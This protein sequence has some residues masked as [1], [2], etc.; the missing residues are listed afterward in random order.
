MT[1]EM[2]NQQW[3][4][5]SSLGGHGCSRDALR[6]TKRSSAWLLVLTAC[7]CFFAWT[8]RAA[9]V[10]APSPDE[11]A[12]QQ[13][14][15]EWPPPSTPPGTPEK[16]RWAWYRAWLKPHESFFN[17]HERDLFAESVTLNLQGL[18]DAHEVFLNGT[19][20]GAGGAFPP[21]FASGRL[22]FHRH[23]IP[24]GLMEKG[25][26]NE[27]A[28]RVYS[29]SGRGG[30]LEEA[31]F[32]MGYAIE[33]V[34]QGIWQIQW[35]D[36]PKLTGSALMRQ[37]ATAAFDSYRESSRVLGEAAGFVHGPKL[38]P[39]ESLKR[40]RPHPDLA[41][42]GLLQE[43][44]VAQPTHLSFDERGRLYVSQYRQYP[45]PAGLKMI[46]RDKFYRAH[47]DK[48]PLPPPHHVKGRDAITIHE[49]TNGDGVFD[50]HSFFQ[51]GLNLANAALRGR[52]GVWVM[53]PPY[54]LFY[55]DENFDDIP[56]GPPEV[57]LAGFGIEDTHSVATGLVWGLDG[58]LYGSQGS[59]TSSHILRPGLDST[60]TTPAYFE[61]AMVWRYHPKT[62]AYEVFAEGGGNTFGLEIDG[63]GRLFSGH[64]GGETR[65]WHFVQGGYYLKPGL[66]PGKF[67]PQRNPYTFGELKVM[68]PISSVQ[69]FSHL[70]AV[71][72]G[73]SMP[74]GFRGKIF[75]ID[76]IHSAV[77][78]AQRLSKGSTFETTEAGVALGSDDPG[79][80]PVFIVNAPDGAL[81]VAD[82][83]EHYIA[84][85]QHYQSQIDPT[86]GRIY[87]LRDKRGRLERD[88]DLS[89][90]TSVELVGLLSHPNKWHRHMAV[91]L[92]GE[93]RD[94]ASIQML[95]KLVQTRSRWGSLGALWSLHQ[96]AALDEATLL[97]AFAHAEPSVRTWGVRFAGEQWGAHTGPGLSPATAKNSPPITRSLPSEIRSA[98]RK[99]ANQE[100][101]SEVRSQIAA[102]SRRFQ[103][104]QALELAAALANQPEDLIDPF[105]PALNWWIFEH[106][107]GLNPRVVVGFFEDKS[108]WDRPMIANYVLARLARRLAAEGRRQDLLDCARLLRIA[109]KPELAARVMEGL[110]EAFK[111]RSMAEIP[112]E[113]EAALAAAGNQASLLSQLRR[114][115]PAAVSNVLAIVQDPSASLERRILYTSALGELRLTNALPALQSL[116]S[117]RE[118][119]P[120]LRKTSLVALGYFSENHIASSLISELSDAPAAVQAVGLS[121]LLSR[122]AWLQL[123][124]EAIQKGSAPRSLL[125]PNVKERIRLHP[126]KAIR[127]LGSSIQLEQTSADPPPALA[128][129]I[130]GLEAILK[131]GSGNAYAGQTLFESR[132]AACHKL[133]Y[134]GGG[135]GPDL[136]PYQRDNLSTM[137][138]AIL[139]PNAEIREG[140]AAIEIETRDGRSLTGF[141][142]EADNQ[143]LVLRGIDNQN[144]VLRRDEI[145]SLRPTGRS[146]MPEGLLD[147]LN[148]RQLRDFFA[149]L[150]SSQPIAK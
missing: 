62:K 15:G 36:A 130:P 35:S 112:E 119:N 9:E 55:P 41:V 66:D 67:G 143:I 139:N 71:A 37:P 69:R 95:R 42:D 104:D 49:D 111:G 22:R 1:P 107:A 68:R 84:H 140:F 40:L 147:D 110:D 115:L 74:S 13:V 50:K 135:V 14:P 61:G 116:A 57:R 32:V 145:Q 132:C 87:R 2:A 125:T 44:L 26:W 149:Y 76:P 92:L 4:E 117:N 90:K 79:F 46:S 99:L 28:I 64:N 141:V 58:W 54:L 134:K 25:M 56:D 124:L 91:R 121:T 47:Y 150:R 106:H 109:P 33:C 114:Q 96:M 30:F 21:R 86:T 78:A 12:P 20:L 101:N 144:T 18:A 16:G 6:A 85:G 31:P 131:T 10:P 100:R 45:Y 126:D 19:R 43:P 27:I 138:I 122:P 88:V 105:L 97:A 142:R 80:R 59:T 93:R 48:A 5:Q 118:P 17:T 128:Q 94:L 108:V 75:A 11:W 148:D 63:E 113:L 136:T 81:Y 127:D 73:T 120:E 129:N 65:G 77:F 8:V 133:F 3:G 146:L 123:L 51:E 52:K 82:F 38:S 72:E 70:F 39:S 102:S 23:K 83:Y 7:A 34:M 29:I 103:T 89:R 60:N 24:P 53:N 98:L 137:L